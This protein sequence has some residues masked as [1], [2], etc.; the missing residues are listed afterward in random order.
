MDL[1]ANAPSTA[2]MAGGG[3][4]QLGGQGNFWEGVQRECY[5]NAADGRKQA[6]RPTLSFVVR[7]GASAG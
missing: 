7:C 6:K 5:C 1:S 3:G 4:V 2:E